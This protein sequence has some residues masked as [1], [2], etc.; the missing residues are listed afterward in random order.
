MYVLI[1]YV[2][3]RIYEHFEK[4]TYGILAHQSDRRSQDCGRTPAKVTQTHML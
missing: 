1:R 3:V 2:S 4:V